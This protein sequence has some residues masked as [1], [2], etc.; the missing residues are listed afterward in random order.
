MRFDYLG[1][2]NSS[3]SE[4]SGQVFRKRWTMFATGRDWR[5][6]SSPK[7]LL[8][9][10]LCCKGSHCAF[11]SIGIKEPLDLSPILSNDVVRADVSTPLER[12]QTD[13]CD[14]CK[15][16]ASLIRHVRIVL[17]VEK[18]HL[19][20]RDFRSMV[21]WIVER[22]ASQFFP[23][24]IGKAVPIAERFTDIFGVVRLR[25][26][27]LLSIAQ[28]RPIHHRAICDHP[29]NS[30]IKRQENRRRPAKASS[31]AEDLIRRQPEAP[32]ERNFFNLP[33]KIVN[34][35]KDVFI[36]RFPKKLATAFPSS[37]IAGIN[38]PK[39]LGGEKFR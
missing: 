27:S 29:F 38:D 20:R 11:S 28:N 39:A 14:F 19:R 9:P 8:Q 35:F 32:P 12:L 33:W 1:R 36:G 15:S 2:G 3:S 7:A 22:P 6:R 18:H 5:R 26:L 23:V 4:Q 21:P 24:C 30:R 25:S 37:A 31:N 17:G 10:E 16:L 34:D 13:S